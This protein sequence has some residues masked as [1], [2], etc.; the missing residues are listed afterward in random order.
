MTTNKTA[1]L[2]RLIKLLNSGTE[3]Y[4][5]AEHEVPSQ[6]LANIFESMAFAR[7]TSLAELQPF[8]SSNRGEQERGHAAGAELRRRYASLRA[9]LKADPRRIYI[10]HLE[11][12]EDATLDAIDAAMRETESLNLLEALTETRDRMSVCHRKM[13]ELEHTVV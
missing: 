8:L 3:F 13:H 7:E 1:A 6:D 9:A 10:E 11:E 12:I 4:R 2:T 5:Q